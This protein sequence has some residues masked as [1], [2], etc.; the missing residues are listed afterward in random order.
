M[1]SKKSSMI[2]LSGDF[3]IDELVDELELGNEA[4]KMTEI[5]A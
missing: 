2:Q 5:V 1:D 3:D 4:R